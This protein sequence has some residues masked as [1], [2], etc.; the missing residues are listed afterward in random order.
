VF[1]YIDVYYNRERLYS[2]IGYLSPVYGD[3]FKST[4]PELSHAIIRNVME[5]R[6]K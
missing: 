1:D 2:K 5:K 4:F 6:K 3:Y